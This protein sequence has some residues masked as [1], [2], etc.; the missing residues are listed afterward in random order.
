MTQQQTPRRHRLRIAALL[1]LLVQLAATLSASAL[2]LDL[3]PVKVKADP[4][5]NEYHPATNGDHIAWTQNSVNRPGHYDAFI[6]RPGQPRV[7]VNRPGTDGNA[8]GFDGKYLVYTEWKPD[9]RGME[10]I[11]YDTTTGERRLYGT[12]VNTRYSEFRPT[13]S[14]RWLLFARYN[15]DRDS[16]R[17][18]L[19]DTRS[20]TTRIIASGA[21]NRWVYAGQVNGNYLTW[22]RVRPSGEDVYRYD[23]TTRESTLIPKPGFAHQYNPTTAPDGTIYFWRGGDGCGL[24]VELVRYPL[25]GPAE[26]IKALPPYFDSGYSYVDERPDGSRTI[27]YSVFDCRRPSRR[28]WDSYRIVDSYTLAVVRGGGGSGSVTSAPGDVDCGADCSDVYPRGTTVTLTATPDDSSE[29]GAWSAP[30]CPTAASTCTFTVTT[31]QTVTV[32]F[33]AVEP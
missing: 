14:G 3:T 26:L 10:I 18:V 29:I 27:S 32:R 8:G 28:A 21:G 9:A 11:R 23:I 25:G 33:D 24:A 17:V 16:Y 13:L 4:D 31:N 12:A 6:Q 2:E 22:G 15:W 1:V 30:E 7:K 5:F 20:R 19:F